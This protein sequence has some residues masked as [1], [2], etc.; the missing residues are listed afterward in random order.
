MPPIVGNIMY[1]RVG[2]SA[3]FMSVRNVEPSMK[4]DV[5]ICAAAVKVMT[6]AASNEIYFFMMA[7]VIL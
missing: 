3:G 5:R 7:V 1:P 4:Y 6:V 2:A